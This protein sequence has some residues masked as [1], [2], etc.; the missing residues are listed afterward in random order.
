MTTIPTII[1][2]CAIAAVVAAFGYITMH[3]LVKIDLERHQNFLD[4]MLSIVGTL[5]SIL[6]GLLVAAA[7]DRYHTLE[8][9]VD[10]E[11]TNVSQIFRLSFGL[12]EPSRTN[13]RKLCY[14]YCMEV[15]NDEW[16]LMAHGKSSDK[17]FFVYVDLM[18]EIVKFK[19]SDNGETNIHNA[20]IA[21]IQ[22][23][24]DGRRERLLAL[25]S[26]WTKQLMPMLLLCSGIVLTFSFL[27]VKRGA[28]LHGVLICLVAIALGGNLGLVFLL[29]NPFSGDWKIQPQGFVY[30]LKLLERA[31]TEPAMRKE[32]LE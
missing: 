1:I 27:Y 9:N 14:Q 6:L 8:Q 4:A 13:I 12:P 17:V 30:N 29:G 10:S 7:L 24:G 11:A 15:V 32:L 3:R 19:P 21:A 20:L 22:A 28:I 23:V 2:L 5:V 31:K 16:P 25:Q 26:T 18:K